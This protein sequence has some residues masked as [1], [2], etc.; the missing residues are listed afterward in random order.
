MVLVVLAVGMAIPN[1]L[2]SARA[3]YADRRGH[4]R[5]LLGLLYYCCRWRLMLAAWSQALGETLMVCNGIV[6]LLVFAARKA[7]V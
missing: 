3:N 5:A 7:F 1:I 2:G 6:L 4:R